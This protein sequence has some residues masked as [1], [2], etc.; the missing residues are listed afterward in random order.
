MYIDF[1]KIFR[2]LATGFVLCCGVNAHGDEATVAVASNFML[3]ANQLEEAFELE[4]EHKLNLVF[5]SSGRFYAQISNGAPFDVFLSADQDKP[6]ALIENKLAASNS[7]FTY[8]LGSL[9][10]WSHAEDV[11]NESS[12]VLNSDRFSK[13]AIA[14]ERVAP[15]GVAAEE[16]ITTLNLMTQV[17]SRLVRGENISQTF[18]FVSTGNAEL[19][20]VARSQVYR[21]DTLIS[22]SAW[23]VPANLH[24]PIRQ[25]AVLLTRAVEN[26]AALSFL[27]FLASDRGREIIQSFGYELENQHGI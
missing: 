10:L 23:D 27:E 12:D 4:T 9:V 22:G 26:T 17:R 8:A 5:G 13:L 15:Y 14:N 21:E 1:Y 19:G 3:A 2:A 20:F 11:V 7:L 24:N 25:D 16:V 18:Q 6:R